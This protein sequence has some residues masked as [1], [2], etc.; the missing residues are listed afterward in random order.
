MITIGK[1][2]I[3]PEEKLY[4]LLNKP[5]GFTIKK[6]NKGK[7]VFDLVKKIEEKL[8]PVGNLDKESSGLLLLTNDNE[9]LKKLTSESIKFKKIYSVS[10][11]KKIKKS[12]VDLIKSGLII[13]NKKISVEK[14]IKLENDNEV[15]IEING[16]ENKIFKK[17]FK[18]INLK[19]IKLDRVMIG[20]LTKKDLPRGKWRKLK[21]NEIRNLKSFLN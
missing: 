6:N 11:N 5:K 12:D 13:D 8:S 19:I 4:I 3:I 20:P 2:Q 17:I 1:E 16:D 18:K 21:N 15:G 14:A 7:G 10:L 9:L